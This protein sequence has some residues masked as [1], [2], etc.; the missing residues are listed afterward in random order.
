MSD[1]QLHS[2]GDNE[3]LTDREPDISLSKCVIVYV[4][5]CVVAQKRLH[6]LSTHDNIQQPVYCSENPHKKLIFKSTN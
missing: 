3:E 6:S 4:N 2:I 1:L 5:V